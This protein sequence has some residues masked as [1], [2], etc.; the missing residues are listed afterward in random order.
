MEVMALR[1]SFEK[2]LF[3]WNAQSS[4]MDGCDGASNNNN[5]RPNGVS[6]PWGVDYLRKS[7]AIGGE[8][9]Y[10]IDHIP[11]IHIWEG[12][13][14]VS[15]L[16]SVHIPQIHFTLYSL[17]SYSHLNQDYILNLLQ[18]LSLFKF[19]KFRPYKISIFLCIKFSHVFIYLF[20]Y[21]M[22]WVDHFPLILWV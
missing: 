17:L 6:L 13:H 2:T 11:I 7:C 9:R 8:E 10:K 16:T 14:V 1:P 4:R 19:F 20:I 15:V 18:F 5:N 12:V 22:D 21:F 3:D